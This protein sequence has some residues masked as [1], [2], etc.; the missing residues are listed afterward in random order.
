MIIKQVEDELFSKI[1]PD[2]FFVNSVEFSRLNDSY[3][4]RSLVFENNEKVIG[5]LRIHLDSEGAHVGAMSP[6]GS[7]CFKSNKNSTRTLS[8]MS[9]CFID[10]LKNIEIFHLKAR[11]P[12][13]PYDG[14]TLLF[15]KLIDIRLKGSGSFTFDLSF[16]INLKNLKFNTDLRRNI[17]LSSA[18][19][20]FEKIESIDEMADLY[21]VLSQNRMAIGA[22]MSVSGDYFRKLLTVADVVCIKHE[23][24]IVAGAVLYNL[25]ESIF[26][27]W[28]GDCLETRSLRPMYLLFKEILERYKNK[29]M[30]FDL[31]TSTSDSE[32]N[33]GLTDYKLGLGATSS[34]VL[35]YSVSIDE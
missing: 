34:M 14:R 22:K 5:G 35:N 20:N 27:A 16:F 29:F 10:Y 15:F 2:A 6:F 1:F 32:I 19:L 4:I 30:Y 11:I 21:E 17:R 12:S 26:L 33:Y 18:D 23:G 8:N 7:I 24:R 9:N 13:I 28:W 31:G 25:G 3:C